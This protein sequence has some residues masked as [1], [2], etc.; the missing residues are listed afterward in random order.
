MKKFDKEEL[1]KEFNESKSEDVILKA[2]QSILGRNEQMHGKKSHGILFPED[3]KY[4]VS[5]DKAEEYFDKLFTELICVYG[6]IDEMSN[7]QIKILYQA[8]REY[9][10]ENDRLVEI[11]SGEGKIYCSFYDAEKDESFGYHN[12]GRMSINGKEGFGFR[13]TSKEPEY[14]KEISSENME[15]FISDNGILSISTQGEDGKFFEQS[16][17]ILTVDGGN[18][19]QVN[20]IDIDSAEIDFGRCKMIVRKCI[21]MIKQRSKEEKKVTS[22]RNIINNN[23]NKS[24]P[25]D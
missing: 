6:R 18:H 14:K 8:F 15:I 4:Y 12:I 16:S 11:R 19:I 2:T 7:E 1:K 13:T 5:P 22:I 21:E 9:L 20:G 24:D 3:S 10:F 25:R 17:L 23:N